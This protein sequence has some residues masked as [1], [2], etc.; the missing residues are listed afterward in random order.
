[1]TDS[2][3]RVSSDEVS[4]NFSFYFLDMVSQVR[5]AT[6]DSFIWIMTLDQGLIYSE[7]IAKQGINA[8]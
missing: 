4:E 6:N 2:E 1:M 7:Q 5:N 3:N 8:K